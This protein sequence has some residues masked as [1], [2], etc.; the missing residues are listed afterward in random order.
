LI[1][2]AAKL[3]M[4]LTALIQCCIK[5]HLNCICARISKSSLSLRPHGYCFCNCIWNNLAEE[6]VTSLYHQ[7]ILLKTNLINTGIIRNLYIIGRQK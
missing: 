4:T 3:P 2:A 1:S 6:I 5:T 7:I